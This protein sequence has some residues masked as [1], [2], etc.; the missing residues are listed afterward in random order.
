MPTHQLLLQHVDPICDRP[1]VAIGK[2]LALQLQY[3]KERHGI[4]EERQ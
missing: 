1:V 4:S 2:Q 3:N